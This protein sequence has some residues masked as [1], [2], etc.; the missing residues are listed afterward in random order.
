MKVNRRQFSIFAVGAAAAL[1]YPAVVR[2][3][4]SKL[5]VFTW[6]GYAE[7]PFV[8]QFEKD[9]HCKVSVTYTSSTDEMFAKVSGSKGTDFDIVSVDTSSINRYKKQGLLLPFDLS[10]LPGRNKLIKVFADIK[11][12]SVG[13]KVLAQPIAWGGLP[14]VYSNKVFKTAPDSWAVIWDPK[15]AQQVIGQDDAIVQTASAALMLGLKNPFKLTDDQFAAVKDKLIKI[16]R[17]ILSYYAG[18]DDGV[19]IFMDNQL[20]LM[21]S[22]GE[23]QIKELKKRGADI[24]Y[25]IPKEGAIGWIDCQSISIG[26]RDV[27]LAHKWLE[28]SLSP[29]AASMIS[30]RIG[31]G[32]AVDNALN[33]KIGLTYADKLTFLEEPESVDRRVKLWDEVKIA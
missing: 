14:L 3:Q 13:G 18:S 23:H 24:G 25:V 17:N 19:R 7:A 30:E 20:A 33:E 8:E 9:N 29:L 21:Q 10:L 5:R 15:Y 11:S 4:S 2:A 27:G 26:A 32:N 28:A 31:Y 6:E 1:A 16:K 12:I 22:F